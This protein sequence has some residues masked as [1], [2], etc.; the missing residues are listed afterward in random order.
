MKKL[1]IIAF[2]F[3]GCG[4]FKDD[5]YKEDVGICGIRQY[6]TGHYA[7]DWINYHCYEDY[8]ENQCLGEGDV[9]EDMHFSYWGNDKT[10]AS[11]CAEH[12][13]EAYP[14]TEY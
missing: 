10:C 8:T 7:T 12:L 9:W 2:L 6:G 1:L 4:I 3:V 5:V 14:C 11:W 13:Y